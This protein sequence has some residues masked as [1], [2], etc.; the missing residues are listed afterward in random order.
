M[1]IFNRIRF[2]SRKKISLTVLVITLLFIVFVRIDS[3]SNNELCWDVF[4]YYLYLPATFIHHD[5]MLNDI[6]WIHKVMSELPISGTLYQL[7]RGPDNNVYFFLMGMSILYGPFFFIGHIIA[8][9]THFE[10][11]GFSLPYQYSIALGMLV[12][13]L[14]GL[15]LLRKILLKFFDDRIV[16]IVLAIIVIGTNY[17]HFVTF[18][19]IDTANSLFFLLA[20]TTWFTLRWHETYRLKHLIILSIS[21]ALTLLV[22]PSEIVCVLIPIFWGVYNKKTFIDKIALIFK[23]FRQF[24][25][26]GIVFGLVVLP[27][28]LYWKLDTG[29][30]LFDSYVNPGVGLDFL[31]PHI[32]KILFSF[33]KGWLLYTPVMLFAL[34]GFIYL[35]KSRKDIFYAILLYFLTTF[36]IIASWT[37]WWY[38]ARPMITT[39]VVLSIPLGMTINKIFNSRIITKYLFSSII[40]FF[41]ALNLF[42]WWQLR[43]YILDP[44]RTT[45][46]YYFAIFGK[47][48]IKPETRYLLSIERSFTGYEKFND[49]PN[50]EMRNIGY[51]DFSDKDTNLYNYYCYDS[52]S[53]SI[54][55]KLDSTRTFS[56]NVKIP[57]C[58]I[59]NKDHAWLRSRVDI[60][61]PKGYDEEFPCL[62]MTFNR[63]EGNYCYRSN[64]ISQETYNTHEGKW[65]H[66]SMDY[67][68][69]EIRN[70]H[71]IFQAY[72]WHRG[73][74]P[75]YIDNFRVNAYTLMY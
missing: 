12:Y 49:T 45:R 10:P 34:F 15:L 2:K 62:I 57:Y 64:C 14:L 58:G 73:K 41:I 39:Y 32:V 18:K 28:V 69:P 67:L 4:G 37:E 35:Y 8:L 42:Q 51:Y 6:T 23:N 29:Q 7:N 44:Y 16:A 53:R 26:A 74:K 46:K 61:I 19:N 75:I 63:I 54:V 59:T 36:Y 72:I 40:L 55:L 43:H 33:R 56:P 68:T 66:V 25:I 31:S 47:T 3:L 11:D 60:L 17:I 65:I 21:L 9:L 30:F 52:I 50:Y 22:K 48:K 13:T 5:P 1:T 38:G 71:D 24:I 20:V 70:K 27:Q